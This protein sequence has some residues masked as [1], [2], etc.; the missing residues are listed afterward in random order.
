VFGVNSVKSRRAF[1]RAGAGLAATRIARA[2]GRRPNIVLL[3]TDDQ[4]YDTVA[5]LGHPIVQTPN[6]DSLVRGGTTFTNT[7]IMGGTISAICTPSRAMLLTGQHLFHAHDN[8]LGAES[9]PRVERRPHPYHLF[10]ELLGQAGYRTYFAGKWGNGGRILNRCFQESKNIFF[11][12]APQGM[13]QSRWMMAQQ[14]PT[15]EY[16]PSREKIETRFTSE[17]FTDAAVDFIG[18]YRGRDPFFAYVAYLSPHDPRTPPKRFADMYDWRRIPVPANFEPEHRFY[19]G[20]KRIR[21]EMLTPFPRTPERIQQ[22]LALYYGMISEVDFQIGRVLEALRKSGHAEDTIVVFAADNG[23]AVGQ[24]GLLGKQN[25]YDHSIRVPLVLQGPGIP[26][27]KRINTANYLH[28]LFPTLF[29]LAGLSVPATVES[30]SLA[31]LIRNERIRFRDSTFH[32][33]RHLHRAVRKDGWKLISY[34]VNGVGTTQLFDLKADPLE[35]FNLAG[36]PAHLGRLAEL[37]T[38]LRSWSRATD[39]YVDVDLPDWGGIRLGDGE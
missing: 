4:R 25:L 1:L 20:H 24:H 3:L 35:R 2:Q 17:A 27:G 22:E 39:D 38:L 14:D 13:N 9:A 37:R 34:N 32:A 6:M 29:D 31:P 19:N 7:S 30:R 10:P 26:A 5:A 8:L 15:G 28:D 21:D 11:R 36:E 23:L 18:N 33:F 16:A 12:W